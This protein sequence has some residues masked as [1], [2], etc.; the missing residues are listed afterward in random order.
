MDLVVE[1]TLAKESLF[2]RSSDPF[3]GL[4]CPA[5]ISPFVISFA[6]CWNRS[7]SA[8]DEIVLLLE[9]FVAASSWSC[10]LD[11]LVL[12]FG[13]FLAFLVL[14][15]LGI[16]GNRAVTVDCRRGTRDA[17]GISGVEAGSS[18]V[19]HDGRSGDDIGVT[20]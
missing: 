5:L 19:T 8:T 16:S 13:T 17:V 11:C 20:A 7:F 4:I 18:T 9:V 3:V 12:F 1:D 2:N 15:G 14:F 10:V 6:N